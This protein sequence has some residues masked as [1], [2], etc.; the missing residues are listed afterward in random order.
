MAGYRNKGGGGSGGG[1]GTVSWGPSFGAPPL[2]TTS[3]PALS[4]LGITLPTVT[5]TTTPALTKLGFTLPTFT[6]A[7]TPGGTILAHPFWQ[8]VNGASLTAS[9][10][11]ITGPKPAGTV[12]GNLLL[13]FVGTDATTDAVPFAPAGWTLVASR[14]NGGTT[15][16]STKVFRKIAGASEPTSY[17]FNFR[18]TLD[19]ADVSADRATVEL[20]RVTGFDPTT[21]ID[22]QNS[23]GGVLTTDPPC[24]TVTTT[25]D[26][27]LVF[28]WVWHGHTA[29]T[30]D[31]HTPPA[32]HIERTDG[33][34]V[35]V[36]RFGSAN[37]TRVFTA[38]G[39]TGTAVSDC[40]NAVGSDYIVWRV[41]IRP[42]LLTLG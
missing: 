15:T 4:K 37:A 19:T 33:E 26:N 3:T 20:H 17:T 8:S 1:G 30:G 18:N 2:V 34:S 29:A 23:A 25:V 9:A 42:G 21:P 22:V 7:T 6:T 40:T 32:S 13:A 36:A 5:P 41:A 11:N 35:N 24:P 27:C 31:S 12:E 38:A 28:A 16:Q 10:I 14:G 39:P